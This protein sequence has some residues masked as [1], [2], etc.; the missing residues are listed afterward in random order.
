MENIDPTA[1]FKGGFFMK[2]K[3]LIL[4][5]LVF[6][7]LLPISA[8][9]A[10][11]K[12]VNLKSSTTYTKYDVTGNGTKDKFKYT[13]SRDSGTTS[14]YLNGTKRNTIFTAR[15]SN[16]HLV[17]FDNKNVF[18]AVESVPFG[19]I[20]L[21]IYKYNK[22]N[23]KFSKVYSDS[24]FYKY[25][26]YL[27]P[28]RISVSKMSGKTLYVNYEQ[29]RDYNLNRIP[30]FKKTKK[31]FSW[32][33]QYT[34]KLGKITLASRTATVKGTPTFTAGTTFKTATSAPTS[35]Y[36]SFTVKKGDKVKLTKIY[37]PSNGK[38]WYKVKKGSKEGWFQDSSS[39]LLK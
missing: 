35:K 23:K 29:S 19:G 3:L 28:N 14:L 18:L 2:K 24:S 38:T 16:I 31:T 8:N 9:A 30:T 37:F 20:E 25:C 15:G 34:V 39:R 21:D 11:P 32:D 33:M 13:V 36:N 26:K 10:N 7:L 17:S 22:T 27:N 12:L 6:A 1:E 4:L 5:T